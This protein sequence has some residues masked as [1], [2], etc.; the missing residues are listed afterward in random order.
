MSP[1][2]SAS[3]YAGNKTIQDTS[4][5][6][7]SERILRDALPGRRNLGKRDQRFKNHG[8]QFDGARKR[9]MK[10]SQAGLDRRSIPAQAS[11]R[12]ARSSSANRCWRRTRSRSSHGAS[13]TLCGPSMRRRVRPRAP[14]RQRA[15]SARARQRRTRAR[16]L[17]GPRTRRP[18]S[19]RRARRRSTR[20]RRT[21]GRSGARRSRSSSRSSAPALLA[22]VFKRLPH[23]TKQSECR[24]SRNPSR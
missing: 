22:K 21:R 20:S 2:R 16:A 7:V 3:S 23:G 1:R 4:I 11:S 10:R 17:R 24:E 19:G 9:E 15:L 5:V 12:G 14:R 6:S 8:E 13:A 18:N